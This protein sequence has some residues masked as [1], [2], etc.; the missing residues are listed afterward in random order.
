MKS[1]MRT[2]GKVGD[3]MNPRILR[4]MQRAAKKE[5]D[6][7]KKLAKTVCIA[8]SREGDRSNNKSGKGDAVGGAAETTA[9][10]HQFE[11]FPFGKST[12][13]R[14]DTTPGVSERMNSERKEDSGR[15]VSR[16]TADTI[17]RTTDLPP[18][19]WRRRRSRWRW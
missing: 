1:K 6:S 15:K 5:I 2:A 17:E 16:T 14:K 13:L 3:Q 9:T 10:R 7:S 12:Q 8:F 18:K 4:A 11:M 19:W